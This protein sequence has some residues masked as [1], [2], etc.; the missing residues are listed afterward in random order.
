MSA[1]RVSSYVRTT[2]INEH[3]I[4]VGHPFFSNFVLTNDLAAVFAYI[5]RQPASIDELHAALGLSIERAKSAVN[6]LQQQ[7]LILGAAEDDETLIDERVSRLRN[8]NRQASG[9]AY[10]GRVY[11]DY[12]ALD[13]EG[14]TMQ[15]QLRRDIPACVDVL[16]VGGCLTHL[17]ADALV[18]LGKRLG[19]NVRTEEAFPELMEAV[20]MQRPEVVVFQCSLTSVLK[21]LWDDGAF[22]SDEER[23]ARLQLMK[24]QL[25]SSLERVRVRTPGAL[26][27]V[28]GFAV[29][30]YSPL[31]RAEFRCGYH[32][33][34]IVHELNEVIMAQLRNDS[35]AMF[36]DEER[37]L[38]NE[39]KL[40][41]TDDAVSAFSHHG[42]LDLLV[43]RAPAGPSRE[44]TF[45]IRQSHHAPQL[46]ART[47]LE[48]FLMWRGI[49][50][51]KC[52]IVDLDNTLWPGL[53]SEPDFDLDDGAGTMSVGVYGGIHQALRI[54][55]QRGVLLAVCSRNNEDDVRGAWQQLARMADAAGLDHLLK[56]EDFVIQKVSWRPKSVSVGEIMTALGLAAEAVLFIDDNGIER[57]EVQTAYPGLRTLGENM[58]MVRSTLLDD[59]HLQ[60]FL[61]TAEG[62][63]RS[64]MVKAQL[65]RDAV[66]SEAP[67]ELEFLRK[68]AVR[69]CVTRLRGP[70]RL[71]RL[72]ELVQRTNQFNTSLLRL[73][74]EELLAHIQSTSG[75]VYA[76]EASD[77]F[78][79]Y[80]LVGLCI[81]ERHEVLAFVLSCRIIPLRAEVPFLVTA[82]RDYGRAPLN[83]RIVEGPRNQPC[84]HLF[85]NAGFERSAPGEYRLMQLSGLPSIDSSLYV[86]EC[87]EEPD[88]CEAGSEAASAQVVPP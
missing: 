12:T 80:G 32:F 66:R 59:P 58:N 19:L 30:A 13:L 6:F 68:L 78:A 77:R 1:Y 87:S 47:Y 42:P 74:S 38:A 9:L 20:L 26:L 24:E 86:M 2:N 73:S 39:G 60:N 17:A 45:G 81:L 31:G 62:A 36:I 28:H 3:T 33:Y 22:L 54:L 7:H 85:D 40:R 70:L 84:R 14:T 75:A 10:I 5:S 4:F 23:G 88:A 15:Q 67:S 53:A 69:L 29:P 43:G 44:E 18:R 64:S 61:P 82:L 72:V 52:V 50:R 41:L 51:I 49:G 21:P 25:T 48:S 16:V 56:E 57:Q 63:A 35:N 65:Q 11:R 46:F 83:G 34:R 55:K 8:L 76:L 71:S 27:L 79:N 37:L